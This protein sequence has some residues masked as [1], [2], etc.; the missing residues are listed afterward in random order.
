MHT[1]TSRSSTAASSARPASSVPIPGPT[2]HDCVRAASA[3]SSVATTSGHRARTRSAADPAVA[4]HAAGREHGGTR[5]QHGRT[6]VGRRS[7]RHPRDALGV[8]VV[9]RAGHRPARR[10]V[11]LAEDDRV[12][13]RQLRTETD[14]DQLHGTAP[15]RGQ[16]VHGLQRAEGDRRG[17]RDGGAVDGAGVGVDAAGRVDGQHRDRA[18]A[19]RRRPARRPRDA[20]ARGRRGRRC[21]RAR[22]PHARPRRRRRARPRRPGPPPGATPPARRRGPAAGRAAP[23]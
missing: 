21:R 2:A 6:R 10:H 8:L 18:G 3:N 13:V 19:P 12:R 16:H 15:V 7:G 23:R 4:H 14:V 22:G 11:R 17:S 5:R 20:A 9:G 1:G